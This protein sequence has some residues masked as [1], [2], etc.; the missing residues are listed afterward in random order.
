MAKRSTR[1]D[2]ADEDGVI[3][4]VDLVPSDLD[5]YLREF[6]QTTTAGMA[7]TPKGDAIT[8]ESGLPSLSFLKASFKTKSAAIRHMDSLGCDVKTIAQHLGLRYQHVR[9]VL[10]NEL[11]RGPNEDFR[12]DDRDT[13]KKL[14]QF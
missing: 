13:S 7:V 1:H 11:K 14:E 2:I 6:H 10:H 3:P 12:L 4:A 5:D 8:M 9:N